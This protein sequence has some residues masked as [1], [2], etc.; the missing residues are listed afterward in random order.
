MAV[1]AGVAQP[2][3]QLTCNQQV[4]G[5]SPFASLLVFKIIQDVVLAM[6]FKI[7]TVMIGEVPKRPK[8]AGCKPAGD[9]LRGFE[10]SPPHIIECSG[11]KI[12]GWIQRTECKRREM[13]DKGADGLTMVCSMFSGLR[14]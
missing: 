2:E 11:Q 3:E 9:S 13:V 7:G 10:S 6:K 4:G 5:S 12:D 1:K 14:V 8:G